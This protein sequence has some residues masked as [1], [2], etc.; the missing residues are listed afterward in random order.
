MLLYKTILMFLCCLVIYLFNLKMFQIIYN[1]PVLYGFLGSKMF[2]VNNSQECTIIN[3]EDIRFNHVSV[4]FTGP[5][6]FAK[7]AESY[8]PL[9]SFLDS[10]ICV[11]STIHC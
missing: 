1:H 11:A 5:N 7:L 10:V 3:T 8:E 6:F 9:H 4:S 2:F